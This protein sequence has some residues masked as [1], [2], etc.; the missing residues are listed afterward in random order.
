MERALGVLSNSA[1]WTVAMMFI[2][3]GALVRTGT[4]ALLTGW[5]SARAENYPV[6]VLGVLA[7]VVL[8]A[9]AFMN[10]TPVVVVL[11]PVA[12]KLANTL[13]AAA[14]KLLIPLSY[15]AILGG[16]CTLIGTV[17]ESHR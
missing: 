1:P 6:L 16:M 13:G 3:S 17:H 2:L 12:I 7:C 14:S 11:I 9:S 8:F 15:V 5:V 4:L 10:N